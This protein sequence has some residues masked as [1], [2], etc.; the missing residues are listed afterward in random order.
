MADASNDFLAMHPPPDVP[1]EEIRRR[2]LTRVVEGRDPVAAREALERL[3][4]G[5]WGAC[6]RCGAPIEPGRLSIDPTTRFC[7]GCETF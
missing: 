4:A 5:T 2:L 3:D 6:L 7:R 1:V